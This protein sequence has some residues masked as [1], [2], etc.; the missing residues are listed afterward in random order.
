MDQITPYLRE[1]VSNVWRLWKAGIV[2]DVGYETTLIATDAGSR[3]AHF[4]GKCLLICDCDPVRLIAYPKHPS[5]N[6]LAFEQ[7]KCVCC[8]PADLRG[9]VAMP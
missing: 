2:R 7:L 4:W 8:G 1:E 6:R 5:G 3:K 9:D